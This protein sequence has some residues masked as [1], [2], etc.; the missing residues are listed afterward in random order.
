MRLFQP[1]SAG[2]ARDGT[3][4]G[5]TIVGEIVTALGGTI[6]LANRYEKGLVIGMNAVVTL[7]THGTK[8]NCDIG[9]VVVN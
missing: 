9:P 6:Q 3:G 7:A 2:N 8:P 1:F 5:L 4:L